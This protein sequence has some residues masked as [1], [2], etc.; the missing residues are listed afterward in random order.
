MITFTGI[1]K[2]IAIKSYK[3]LTL[4]IL[5]ETH[6]LKSGEQCDQIGR[7]FAIWQLLLEHF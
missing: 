7:N 5:V 3:F 6:Y 1:E 4:I 2:M